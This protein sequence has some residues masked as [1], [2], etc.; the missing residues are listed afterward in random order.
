MQPPTAMATALE[1]YFDDIRRY[2]V[3]SR[4]AE[5]K[6]T[7]RYRR[8]PSPAIAAELA[9]ANLR[10]VVKIAREYRWSHQ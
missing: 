4:A 8:T 6:L 9:T 2:P 5:L 1:A 3:L 10:L 7:R